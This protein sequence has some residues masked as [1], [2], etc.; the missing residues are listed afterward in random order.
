MIIP[1][2][3]SNITRPVYPNVVQRLLQLVF[4]TLQIDC[5]GI[6]DLGNSGIRFLQSAV[7]I[8]SILQRLLHMIKVLDNNQNQAESE[9]RTSHEMHDW[10]Q[11]ILLWMIPI[12]HSLISRVRTIETSVSSEEVI[13]FRKKLVEIIGNVVR[14]AEEIL[15]RKGGGRVVH[16]FKCDCIIWP[17]AGQQISRVG[18]VF[19]QSLIFKHKNEV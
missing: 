15:R 7:H 18:N 6:E 13:I 10:N 5:Q 19:V 9:L 8:S 11:N 17:N 1:S 14:G 16:K 3:I 2:E 4:H 12:L